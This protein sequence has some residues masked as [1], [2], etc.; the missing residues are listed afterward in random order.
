[1]PGFTTHYLFGA[2]VLDRLYAPGLKEI[3]K[4]N[5]KVYNLGL[6][7]PDIFFYKVT[8]HLHKGPENPGAYLHKHQID[9][10]FD[11]FFEILGDMPAGKKKDVCAAYTFGFLCHYVLD[12]TCHPYIYWKTDRLNK[13][14]RNFTFGIHSEIETSID[15]GILKR[16]R[17]V[18]PLDFHADETIALSEEELDTVS[19]FLSAAINRTYEHAPDARGFTVSPAYVRHA[20]NGLKKGCVL[21]RDRRGIKKKAVSSME[22]L[23]FRYPVISGLFVTN[24]PKNPK[25]VF[26]EE[27]KKWAN[28]WDARDTS[29]A[30][31]PDMFNRALSVCL[32]TFGS[33]A[34]NPMPAAADELLRSLTKRTYHGALLVAP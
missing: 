3:L 19:A 8:T 2:Q 20:I 18:R 34:K 21:L 6:Q 10:L 11:S 16:Y 24:R 25:K 17:H 26:N 32:E 27:H 29:T 14:K 33:L 22:T 13:E 30:S 28:P 1:M 15:A 23:L 12:S 9:D 5:R 4:E 31:V 7:G